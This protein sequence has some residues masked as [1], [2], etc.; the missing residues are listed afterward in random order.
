[1]QEEIF[2]ALE[3]FN[4][5]RKNRIFPFIVAIILA[6]AATVANANT[7]HNLNN[8]LEA[9][10]IYSMVD[11]T[12]SVA[13]Q[14]SQ[15][16]ATTI[17]GQSVTYT[18]SI[19]RTNFAG[20]V[21]L[22]LTTVGGTTVPDIT[23]SYSQN[24]T[25]ANSVTLTV[26]TT[27]TTPARN[28][29]FVVTGKASR[30]T[31]A[32]SNVLTLAVTPNTQ[33]DFSLSASP[34]SLIV[35]PGDTANF[36][37]SRVNVGGGSGN[38][39]LSVSDLPPGATSNLSSTTSFPT[40]LSIA[41]SSNTPLGGYVVTITGTR[42][43]ITRK[44]PV[45][46][47]VQNTVATKSVR[48]QV[49]QPTKTINQGQIAS[50]SVGLSRTNF[51]APVTLNLAMLSNIAVPGLAF[52]YSQNPTTA[53]NVGLNISTT[54]STPAGTYEFVIKGTALGLTI[55]DSSVFTL[56][57][58]APVVTQPD[59]N[60]LLSPS[61][62]T[63]KPGETANF[64]LS[65]NDVGGFSSNLS[66]NVTGIPSN[67]TNGLPSSFSFPVTL[68]VITSNNT[69]PGTYVVTVTGTGGGLTRT[70]SATLV[71]Q[72][73]NVVKSVALQ[74]GQ[75]TSTITQG[76]IA[77]YPVSI[78]RTNFT[79]SVELGLTSLNGTTI[80]GLTFGYSQNP[81]TASSVS[82]NITTTNSIPT[83]VYNFV[84]TGKASGIA[85]ADSNVFTLVVN[86]SVQQDFNLSLSP[87]SLTVRPG[88]TASFTL[89][90]T[91][92]AGFS[93]NVA[94]SISNLPVGAT[95]NVSS[96]N[97]SVNS[98]PILTSSNTPVGTYAVTIT[99]VSG[100]LT[101]TASATLVVEAVKPMISS[102][103]YIK[104]LLT[105]NGTNFATDTKV[106]VNG[107][108]VSS[109]IRD[110]STSLVSLKGNKKKL[111]LKTGSNQIKLLSNGVE[112]NTV[113]V[114]AF[115][116]ESAVFVGEEV[117]TVNPEDY[118]SNRVPKVFGSIDNDFI[119]S[120]KSISV[121]EEMYGVRED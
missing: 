111:N 39:A 37:L 85:I 91:N 45:T 43:T 90:R 8:V 98:L 65:R 64:A 24:P 19:N 36:T 73:I 25:T 34:N 110:I 1:M 28:Y 9:N 108:E 66:I 82:L 120:D 53:N 93:G 104:P 89:N 84:V 32:D 119:E 62:L 75:V 5:Y 63:V 48:I 81:T 60:L 47:V 30:I 57:V 96:A 83:G 16:S 35:R 42:G 71:V 56:I 107:K 68:P 117:I 88:E 100:N 12:Q 33:Q 70:S 101:R 22:G 86:S 3:K 58:K 20:P 76:Q 10:S 59:F 17:Q 113:V 29:N 15:P 106:F 49:G 114:A 116:D 92:I 26:N 105:I 21:E 13:L 27:G 7:N 67:S 52:T 38:V 74:V 6:I 95:T 115:N 11:A 78:N 40:T 112:S 54:T 14:V 94:L 51:T 99:G 121:Q 69:P 23:F 18:V 87:S 44:I 109:F 118:F 79:E 102:V 55:P 4:L 97:N 50:Y 46:I 41:T 31:I 77:S 2:L 72:N 103:G 61:S 80:S